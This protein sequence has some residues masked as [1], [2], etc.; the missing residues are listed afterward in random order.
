LPL[1]LWLLVPPALFLLLPLQLGL[2]LRF[3]SVCC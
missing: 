3:N 1:P 2:P